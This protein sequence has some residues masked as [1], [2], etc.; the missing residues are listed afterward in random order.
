MEGYVEYVIWWFYLV[1]LCDFYGDLDMEMEIDG[2]GGVSIL[3]K[4]RVFCYGVYFLVF[5]F[6]KYV[7]IEG[8]GKVC[9]NF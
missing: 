6:E 7:E 5:S 3:V 4:V 9:C 1:Y 8:F 2:V